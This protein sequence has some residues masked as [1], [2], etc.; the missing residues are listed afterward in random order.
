MLPHTGAFMGMKR[1]DLFSPSMAVLALFL[2][3][4]NRLPVGL[5][6]EAGA[7]VSDL[8][9]V[10]A[11]LIDVKEKVCLPALKAP[12]LPDS[13]AT[14]RFRETAPAASAERT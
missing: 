14:S 3:P 13:A 1:P 4:Q 11:R 12:L 9:A 5:E 6:N 2:G 10:A 8:D 7:G